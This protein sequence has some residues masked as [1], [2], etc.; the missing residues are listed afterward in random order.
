MHT[1]FFNYEQ[2]FMFTICQ[3]KCV[4]GGG[5]CLVGTAMNIDV[6]KRRRLVLGT[7]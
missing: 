5:R 6:H 7:E 3:K 4:G 2:F 1:V